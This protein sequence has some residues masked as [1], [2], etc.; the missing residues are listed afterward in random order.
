[1]GPVRKFPPAFNKHKPF[2]VPTTKN[3][4]TLFAPWT[5]QA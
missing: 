4:A 3:D 1:L 2:F 5:K